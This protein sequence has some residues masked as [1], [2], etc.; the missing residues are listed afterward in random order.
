LADKMV[1]PGE[2]VFIWGGFDRNNKAVSPGVYPV[3]VNIESLGGGGLLQ[4][5]K[6]IYVGH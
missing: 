4:T 1:I 6:V 3:Y 5:R 2:Y